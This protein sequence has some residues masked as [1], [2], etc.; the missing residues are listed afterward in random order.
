ML[1]WKRVGL[2]VGFPSL[3][4][5]IPLLAMQVTDEVAWSGADF[6]VA[7]LLLSGSVALYGWI[8]QA[9]ACRGHRMGAAAFVLALLF[10]VWANLAVG[11]IGDETHPGNLLYGGVVLVALVWGGAVRFR[12]RPMVGVVALVA[13]LLA[14]V[15]VVS[16]L[17]LEPGLPAVEWWSI[18]G[19]NAFFVLMLAVSG[20]LFWRAGMR[21]R[22]L[23]IRG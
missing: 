8:V 14:A 7:F 20:L 13:A 18:A 3:V 4:L 12:A 6:L 2:V 16:Y 5:L 9:G 10:L 1:I 15:P 23:W 19:I 17:F 21:E 11:I 22:Q